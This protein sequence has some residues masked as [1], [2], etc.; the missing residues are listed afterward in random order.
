VGVRSDKSSDMSDSRAVTSVNDIF[1]SDCGTTRYSD[2]S[3]GSVVLI[4]LIIVVRASALL[5]PSLSL[6]LSLSL[7]VSLSLDR[8]KCRRRNAPAIINN[9]ASVASRATAFGFYDRA[10]SSRRL[11]RCWRW[12]RRRW[13][14][15]MVD[16]R[17]WG[18]EGRRRGAER[19][20]TRASSARVRSHQVPSAQ[21]R[22]TRGN[23]L[24]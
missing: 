19:G 18:G 14:T 23:R 15:A 4:P 8:P 5:P 10:P 12:R 24:R 16:G 17:V 21:N 11:R 1:Q 7:C 22:T 20:G 13:R 9:R 3:S 2:A 6:S